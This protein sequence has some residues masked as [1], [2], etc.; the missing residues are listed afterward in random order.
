MSR[1]NHIITVSRQVIPNILTNYFCYSYPTPDQRRDV[2]RA[3]IA[4]H[5]FLGDAGGGYVRNI[6][7]SF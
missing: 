5:L 1:I 3:V 4:K 7:L 2:C 6:H